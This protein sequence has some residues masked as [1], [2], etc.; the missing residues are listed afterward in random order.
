MSVERRGDR[1]LGDNSGCGHRRLHQRPD[2]VVD[3]KEVGLTDG[4]DVAFPG[5]VAARIAE[6]TGTGKRSGDDQGVDGLRICCLEH[7]AQ[8]EQGVAPAPGGVTDPPGC[9]LSRISSSI[10]ATSVRSPGRPR[11]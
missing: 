7:L 4:T 2:D 6:N 5:E 11:P 9:R 3:G 8:A 10:A 1:D